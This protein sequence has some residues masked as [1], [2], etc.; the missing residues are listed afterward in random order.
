MELALQIAT[1]LNSFFIIIL[2]IVLI[3]LL[4]KV[5]KIVGSFKKISNQLNSLVS[6]IKELEDSF[7]DKISRLESEVESVIGSLKGLKEGLKSGMGY[8]LKKLFGKE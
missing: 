5:M 3:V 2:L 1:L 7:R 6:Y 8:F 4:F